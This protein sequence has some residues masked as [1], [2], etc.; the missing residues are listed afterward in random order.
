M[1]V[2]VCPCSYSCTEAFIWPSHEPPAPSWAPLLLPYSSCAQ[3]CPSRRESGSGAARPAGWRAG[4][5]R[6][7]STRCRRRT[8]GSWCA[9]PAPARC[10]RPSPPTSSAG[11]KAEG[12]VGPGSQWDVTPAPSNP[13][14]LSRSTPLK[15]KKKRDE[16]EEKEGGIEAFPKKSATTRVFMVWSW[17]V[18]WLWFFQSTMLASTISSHCELFSMGFPC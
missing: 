5:W 14:A 9:P 15:K 12:K 3:R 7:R 16:E 17:T 4:P 6:T 13:A 11:E 18:F 8:D 1:N 10:W 2:S